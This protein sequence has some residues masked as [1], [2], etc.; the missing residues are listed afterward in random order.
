[1]VNF[2]EIEKRVLTLTNAVLIFAILL[3]SYIILPDK[4]NVD[5]NR[6]NIDCTGLIAT[7]YGQYY[8]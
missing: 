6:Q 3:V 2:G 7:N 4:A 1:M 5:L 8:R